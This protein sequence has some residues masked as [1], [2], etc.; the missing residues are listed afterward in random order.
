MF[1]ESLKDIIKTNKSLEEIKLKLKKELDIKTNELA[2]YLTTIGYLKYKSKNIAIRIKNKLKKQSS[3]MKKQL[4]KLKK[5]K[6]VIERFNP[7][8]KY[9][10][11]TVILPYRKTMILT[12]K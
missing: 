7:W 12:V 4:A 2:E 1:T 10:T 6:I 5:I 9:N 8:T 11:L 3:E